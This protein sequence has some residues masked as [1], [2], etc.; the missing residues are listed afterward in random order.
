[1]DVHLPGAGG[2][3]NSSNAVN[4]AQL[5]RKRIEA[6]T[7]GFNAEEADSQTAMAEIFG[8]K[9][10]SQSVY[11]SYKAKEYGDLAQFAKKEDC[12]CGPKCGC[13][14]CKTKHS[15]SENNWGGYLAVD[16]EGLIDEFEIQ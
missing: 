1:M 13:P 10:Y 14:A 7:E 15:Y 16:V 11:R 3:M 4:A 8:A 5:K 12:G 2:E 9:K 6:L